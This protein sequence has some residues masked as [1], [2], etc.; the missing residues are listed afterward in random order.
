[1]A[2]SYRAKIAID[3]DALRHNFQQVRKAAP[4]SK[5]MAAVKAN[6]Y[7]HGM[8]KVAQALDDAD[9]FAVATVAEGLTLKQAGICQPVV[10]L[11]GFF[12]SAELITAVEQRLICVLH[13]HY[14][15]DILEKQSEQLRHG[16]KVWI[17]LDSGMHR[18][19]FPLSD[20]AMVKSRLQQLHGI[21]V[22]G[23][24]S[25]FSDADDLTN[26]KTQEQ[27]DAFN[28]VTAGLE[29]ERSLANSG[30]IL[31][32]PDSHQGWV[33]PGIMLYGSSPFADKTAKELD[34]RPDMHFSAQIITVNHYRKGDCIGYGSSWRCPEDMPVGVVSVGY[35]DGYP[36]HAAFGTPVLVNGL[37]VPL[38]G[39]V[40]MDM[41]TV[42]L[43]SQPN[44]T[45]G[46]EVVLWGDGLSADR[47][48]ERATTISYELFC[49]ITQRV[50]R[51]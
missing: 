9:A 34:L 19:G 38:I 2:G 50:T 18:L 35:G 42:D 37:Q 44:L 43:R 6:G 20:V 16:L 28:R 46:D 14:Q 45:A 40:S 12:D 5:V 51:D 33:R 30:G 13:S 27:I 15:L 21:A 23:W 41:I 25:H 31:G 26:P 32:W 11:E 1:M 39:R 24:M 7:G 36:R 10:I 29:G 8:V 17:K 49:T 22:V 4:N 47:V 48:A 3:L